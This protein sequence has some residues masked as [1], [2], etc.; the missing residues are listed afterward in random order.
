[1]QIKILLIE[2]NPSDAR[3]LEAMLS[4]AFPQK[5]TVQT[6]T[7]LQDGIKLLESAEFDIILTDLDLPDASGAKAVARIQD[8]CLT[9]P[10]VV[11]SGQDSDELALQTV[12]MG[13]QD[14][15]V[16]GQGD[17]YLLD[18]AIEYAI[19]RK[20]HEQRLSYLAN[21]DSLTGLVNRELFK[22]R[23][24]RALIRANRN[25]AL[26]ALFLIDLDRFK[27]IND[28]LGHDAGDELLIQVARRLEQCTRDEDT[29]ARLDGDEFAIITENVSNNDDAIKIADKILN[30]MRKSFN[31]QS[32]DIYV[33]PSIG[34]SLYPV[35]AVKAEQLLKCADTAIHSA[36][37]TGRNCYYFYTT[38]MNKKLLSRLSLEAKL[39]RAVEKQEFQLYYQPKFNIQTKQLIGAEALIRWFHPEDG[40]VSPGVFIPMAEELGLIAAITDWVLHEACSQNYAWQQAGYAPIRMAVNLSPKQFNQNNVA[41]RISEQIR[42][43]NLSPEYVELEITEGALMN[44]VVKSNEVLKAL[45]DQGIHIS[46]DDFGTGYSS[47]SYL[48]KFY[49]DTLKIDQSFVRDMLEDQDGSAIV[50]AIIAMAN[51]LRLNVIAEGVETET[52]MS[53]LAEK[54][55]Q[56]AQG[57]LLGKPVPAHEFT[58]FFPVAHQCEKAECS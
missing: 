45:K 24:G 25:N 31:V 57:Y 49:L 38:D 47:L 35:N 15:L 7:C 19:E 14:Y 6:A 21:Y 11:L 40:M 39:R 27:T 53:Y 44:D 8:D 30:I 50:S 54:N 13:A 3:L 41:E 58:H 16:K 43:T 51:S 29:V 1:M 36:K 18:R 26:V 17:G 9:I 23:L 55:C 33:S 28:T 34:I 10:I 46:I 48:K 56:Y 20:R 5:Y 2:D 52:Q 4:A 37:D 42:Q 12:Q 22:E 32:N